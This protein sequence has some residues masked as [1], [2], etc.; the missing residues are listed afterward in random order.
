MATL[1]RNMVEG[2]SNVA[3]TNAVQA[4]VSQ[5]LAG[6][7]NMLAAAMPNIMQQ[8]PAFQNVPMLNQTPPPPQAVDLS[9]KDG[10]L[11][12]QVQVNASSQLIEAT[13]RAS[14]PVVPLQ[15]AGGGNT[16]PASYSYGGQR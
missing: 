7:P 12:V 10:K 6:M 3:M 16:N 4:G 5:G 14:T 1:G 2:T 13:A 8:P 15:L 11:Q 9:I